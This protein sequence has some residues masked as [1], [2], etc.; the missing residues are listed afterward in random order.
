[1]CKCGGGE[2]CTLIKRVIQLR[3]IADR[4]DA[5]LLNAEQEMEFL[6]TPGLKREANT[7]LELLSR[8]DAPLEPSTKCAVDYCNRDVTAGSRWCVAHADAP[9]NEYQDGRPCHCGIP[10]QLITRFRDNSTEWYCNV[11]ALISDAPFDAPV[12]P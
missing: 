11:C 1:L 4:I 7:R 3:A 8:L 12:K 2:E 5:E 10:M 6:N 9:V